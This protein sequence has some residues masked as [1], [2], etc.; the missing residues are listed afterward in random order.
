LPEAL[1][2][3]LANL[4]WSMPNEEEKFTINQMQDCFDISRISLGGPIFD[5]EKLEW[6]NARWIRE[7]LTNEQ[8]YAQ[9]IAR[10]F[11]KEYLNKFLDFAKQRVNK[12]SDFGHIANFMFVGD[13]KVQPEAFIH[14]K[15]TAEQTKT[16]LQFSL[17][18]LEGMS[19]WNRE[20]ILTAI[21][22]LAS[23]LEIKLG[24]FNF[25]IFVAIAGTS[26]SWSVMDSIEILGKALACSR[27]KNAISLLGGISKKSLK[28]M[29]K[30]YEAIQ[31]ST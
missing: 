12:I 30:Q 31:L 23:K 1:I 15:L 20:N 17:W 6:L 9:L 24:E 14:K 7:N 3:Y 5:K 16:I 8:F 13:I 28:Q 26:D 2:N 11:N 27:L 25:P 19:V 22:M 18:Q 29:Q 21:K 4:G 10:Y